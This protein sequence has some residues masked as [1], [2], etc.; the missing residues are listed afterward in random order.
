MSKITVDQAYKT[1]QERAIA[2]IQKANSHRI[3]DSYMQVVDSENLHEKGVVAS[4]LNNFSQI[5]DSD[6]GV[7]V[8]NSADFGPYVMEVWPLVTAWYPEFPLK[9]LIS[10][11]DMDK[12]LAY[13][14]FSALK[15][16]TSKGNTVAG[17]V[18]ET[19]TGSR[20]IRGKYP[21]G[22][23][24][25]ETINGSEIEKGEGKQAFMLA[26]Y[27]LNISAIPGYL[28]KVKLTVTTASGDKNYT[29]LNVIG[30]EIQLTENGT[31]ASG[32]TID[33]Q[34]GL[35][36]VNNTTEI[37]KV[38]ANYVWNIDLANPDNVQRVTEEVEMVP[39]E[40]TP[41]A[42]MLE[43]TLFSEYLK[44]SQFG[45]DIR[46]DNTKRILSLLFQ[47][48]LRYILDEMYDYAAGGTVDVNIP[49]SSSLS[50]DVKAQ[51]VM[52]ALKEVANTIE[53]NSGRIEGNRIVCGK[54]FKAFVESLP[55]T[56]FTPTANAN[57]Y[58][59]S[60]PR[61]IGTFGTF[62][63]YYDP[64]RAANEAFM[65]YKGDE[66]YDAAYYL[67]EY[68]PIVPTE[69]IALGVT[70]RSSFVSMEAYKFHKKNC[71]VKLN[72]INA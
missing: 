8:T 11:Q 66:W 10:V 58:G 69:A 65:T 13:M 21:T 23:I 67:G 40:A 28:E 19:A 61:E 32:I 24:F 63:V 71:V 54:N 2:S 57:N 26:Y 50:V 45:Q 18:V 51:Q 52:Q 27:P 3:C 56:W 53:I 17:E 14:F 20:T 49:G 7:K 72:V 15:T 68:M 70:V 5:M 25:G 48:Q 60:S 62:K 1:G 36:T 31:T 22:E 39:M 55:N 47:Y 35:V 4:L 33:I 37:T 64:S 30:N 38:V 44:K 42:L 41:R 46:Q 43:W 34:S 6:L 59:F 29:P 16:G 9:D 12:P